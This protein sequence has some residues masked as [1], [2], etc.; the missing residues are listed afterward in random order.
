MGLYRTGRVGT[1][2]DGQSGQPGSRYALV[3]QLLVTMTITL[4]VLAASPL[5]LATPGDSARADD[6]SPAVTSAVLATEWAGVLQALDTVDATTPSAVLRLLKG[7]ACLAANRNNESVC[8]FMSVRTPAELGAWESWTTALLAANT[9]NPAALYVRADALARGQRRPEALAL[10]ADATTRFP[11][12]ALLLN[13]LGVVYARNDQSR[14]ARLAF[15]EA[16]SEGDRVLADTHANI[17]SLWIQDK[18]GADGALQAFD[19]ALVLNPSFALAR[20]G[21][22]CIELVLKQAEPAWRDMFVAESTAVGCPGAVYA[23]GGNSQAARAR[24]QSPENNTLLAE[25]AA[26]DSAAGVGTTFDANVRNTLESWVNYASD[27][28]PA[29]LQ[30]FLG[31]Y[32]SLRTEDQDAI[33]RYTLNNAT[34]NS[35]ELREITSNTMRDLKQ[36]HSP[37]GAWERYYQELRTTVL[38]VAGL[39]P[40]LESAGQAQTDIAERNS[41]RIVQSIDK[42]E[43]MFSAPHQAAIQPRS[44]PQMCIDPGAGTSRPPMTMPDP[45]VCAPRLETPQRPAGVSISY[46][47]AATDPGQ[48]PF[49]PI[50]GLMYE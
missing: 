38:P 12:D 32:G 13:A 6:V 23:L 50:Y 5:A 4:I 3:S 10:L 21:K 25:L 26:R 41:G 33:A 8:L 36:A 20:H 30:T 43:G 35:P 15:Q 29:T 31:R 22:G 18:D 9:A 19:E 11:K 34:T 44:D 39:V 45:V 1:E 37:G 48:W 16:I 2:L 7:H 46:N 42:L 28:D 14:L 49:A 40:G 24:W 47:D 27:H 17:G